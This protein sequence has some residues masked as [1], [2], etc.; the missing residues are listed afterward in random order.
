MVSHALMFRYQF[1]D[2]AYDGGIGFIY[3]WIAVK[4]L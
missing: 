2:F 3:A 1:I 4:G